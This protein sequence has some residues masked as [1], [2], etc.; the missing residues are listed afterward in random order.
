MTKNM[1]M[2]ESRCYCYRVLNRHTL[3]ASFEF[4]PSLRSPCNRQ[5][6]N[7][8]NIR[9]SAGRLACNLPTFGTQVSPHETQ[10]DGRGMHAKKENKC[11]GSGTK[12]VYTNTRR[13]RGRVSS[14]Q[15]PGGYR[16]DF[17]NF[18]QETAVDGVA[19]GTLTHTHAHTSAQVHRVGRRLAGSQRVGD[20]R[21]DQAVR[22]HHRASRGAR[23]EARVSVKE[24]A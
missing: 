3:G 10:C 17:P 22:L 16:P 15:P 20:G 18:T 12:R 4:N 24:P 13:S 2:L 6:S 9:P 19:N 23:E 1:S 5:D 14:R 7:L 11:R 8:N 21:R